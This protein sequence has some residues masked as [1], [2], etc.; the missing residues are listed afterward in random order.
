MWRSFFDLHNFHRLFLIGSCCQRFRQ[1]VEVYLIRHLPIQAGVW[2]LLVEELDV[3]ADAA[4]CSGDRFQ[5]MQI[6]MLVF[7]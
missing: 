7:E 6:H 2:T 1:A 4:S 3:T 5:G